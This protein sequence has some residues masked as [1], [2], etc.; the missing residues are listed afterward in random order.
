MTLQR[1]A[2]PVM[3]PGATE[4]SATPEVVNELW[5]IQSLKRHPQWLDPLLDGTAGN[6]SFGRPRMAGNWA[7]AYM[8]FV[9]SPEF[10]TT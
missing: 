8:G 4:F 6:S 5:A 3:L 2:L 1:T 10:R 9:A 7:L